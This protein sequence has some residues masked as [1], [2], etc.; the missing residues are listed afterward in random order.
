M[1]V[2][3]LV[4]RGGLVCDGT[5][6]E[7]YE[8]DIA[9]SGDRIVEIGKVT[10]R[11]RDEIDATGRIVTP[12]FI[13]LHTHYDGQ[14]I[15]SE[16]LVPSSQHG[17]TT[18]I[19]GNCGVGFAPCRASDRE[20]LI[21]VMEGVEDIPEVVMTE[22]LPWDWET[23][24]DYLDALDRRRR[25]IDVAAYVPHS[26]LRVYVMGE[27]GA[28]RESATPVDME[29]M[30]TLVRGAMDAGAIGFATSR[31]FIHRTCDGEMIPSFDAAEEE[32]R[33]LVAAMGEDRG[34]FQIVLDVPHGSWTDELHMLR[35]V[36]GSSGRTAMFTLG[37]GTS[38]PNDWRE[39]LAIVHEANAEGRSIRA[40]VFPR[41]IGIIVGLNLSANPFMDRPSY[42]QLPQDLAAR[43][44]ALR[45]PAVR[46]R[47]LAEAPAGGMTPLQAMSNDF[48]RMFP[49]AD[50][51][52]YEPRMEDSV[53]SR[54]RRQGVSPQELAYDLL[55]EDDGHAMLYVAIGNYGQGTLDPIREMMLDEATVVGLGDGG[56]HYGMVCDASFP[57]FMLTHWVRD[58]A[59]NRL[60]LPWVVK[61]LTRDPALAV[62]LHDRGTI[63][64]GMKADLNVIDLDRIRLPKPTV[65][66]DL[67]AGGRRITQDAEGYCA[68]IV[69]GVPIQRDGIATGLLPG[70]LVRGGAQRARQ[71]A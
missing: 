45:D 21:G 42:K 23:F 41:P 66:H 59:E 11:G 35:R 1:S 32:L 71:V 51:P 10:A 20:R 15:W 60:P 22:G 47:I 27:R 58:R 5:G 16:R 34:A 64:P 40:Q 53:A 14:A 67:P 46:A 7:P 48:E 63:A 39:A 55:L 18:A 28:A 44:A 69:S 57:T 29:K 37:Q 50:T 9:I 54:A 49:M 31:Q 33:L 68:T 2:I 43:V 24:P 36:M 70:R 19:L 65:K 30:Q 25:D 52:D 6:S 12:G 56:A 8:A 4:I 3:D 26:A 17:V 61:A 13:D 62:G 38:N